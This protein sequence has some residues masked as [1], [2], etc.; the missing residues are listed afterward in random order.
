MQKLLVFVLGC[1]FSV[2]CLTSVVK[3]AAGDLDPTYGNG[4]KV[5]TDF[6]GGTLEIISHTAVQVDGKLVV[7]GGSILA[8]YKLNGSLDPAFGSG[9]KVTDLV[10]VVP[11]TVM[12]QADGK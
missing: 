5:T 11:G 7:V 2:F 6:Q 8:R 1:C 10:G 4:G 9:G 12:I 3:A